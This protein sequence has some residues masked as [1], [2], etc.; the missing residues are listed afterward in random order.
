MCFLVNKTKD[1]SEQEIISQ[2]YKTKEDIKNLLKEDEDIT[3]RRKELKDN[4]NFLKNSFNILNIEI[5]K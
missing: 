4:L 3:Q 2:L 1:I 5:N